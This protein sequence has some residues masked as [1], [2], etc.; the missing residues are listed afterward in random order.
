L[1][2]T[3]FIN[4]W[5][6]VDSS[7]PDIVG[8]YLSQSSKKPLYILAKSDN[9]WER[10]ISMM[11]TFRFIKQ[12]EF[13]EALK[14][15]ELLLYDK[16]DLIHKAVSWMLREIGKRHQ[17]SEENFLR[18]RYTKM[19]RTMLRYA[20]EKFPEAQRRKYLTGQI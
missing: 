4:N 9:V 16:E 12:G 14:L 1:K 17:Q 6:L 5:N 10:R 7:A 18:K 11:A 15:A 20:I 2:N 13:A 8:D 19:P 3:G